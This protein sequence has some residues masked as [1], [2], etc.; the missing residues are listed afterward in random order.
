MYMYFNIHI[1][2]SMQCL[3]ALKQFKLEFD[4]TSYTGRAATCGNP[5]VLQYMYT[6][7]YWLFSITRCK[8][9][10]HV[11][12]CILHVNQL[13]EVK[14]LPTPRQNTCMFANN[15]HD[16]YNLH[17]SLMQPVYRGGT[18]SRSKYINIHSIHVY[19][20]FICTTS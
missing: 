1:I 16:R 9:H 15:R 18:H 14:C 13:M 5:P 7:S 17:V 3:I 10:I 8:S 2:M 6:H 4:F 20:Y 19:V 12:T 11:C